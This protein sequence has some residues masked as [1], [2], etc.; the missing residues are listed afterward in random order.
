[1]SFRISKKQV[2]TI[3]VR[4]IMKK[5]FIITGTSRGLGLAFAENL[6]DENHALFLISRSENADIAKK[7]LMKNC[8]ISNI[9]FDLSELAK[10]DRLVS[11]LIDHIP[12]DD[13]D[14]IFLINNA[15]T[16]EP[17]KPIDK[18]TQ[19]EIT[20]AAHLNFLA[21]VLLTSALISGT[22]K[23]KVRKKILNITSGAA[24]NPH[25]GMG[26]YC[27]TKAGLDQFT[28]CI[29]LEQDKQKHP[30]E[31]HGI[32]PGFVDTAMLRG[33]GEKSQD[34]FASKPMFQEVISSGKPLNPDAVAKKI[35][36]LWFSEKLKHGRIS[37]LSEY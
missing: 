30:V 15:A 28:R 3:I 31:I 21:P 12:S 13:C 32:S 36:R 4:M 2:K 1:M 10:I 8:R 26:M 11:N 19:V 6:L 9:S 24:T 29:A 37:H 34:D 16:A 18:A 5:Y 20:T 17:V 35:L 14:G 22:K 25:H 23:F 7:A 27:S 33:L